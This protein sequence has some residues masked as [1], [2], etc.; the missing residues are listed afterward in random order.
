MGSAD[1]N[2]WKT[3][4]E[5]SKGNASK[6]DERKE[7]TPLTK[8]NVFEALKAL[9][10]QYRKLCKNSPAEIIIVGGGS[11]LLN[12]NF[13]DYTMDL[14]VI[15]QAASGMKDAILRVADQMALPSDWINTD[16]KFTSSYSDKL[17]QYSRHYASLNNGQI[18]IR[19]INA[20][21]LIAM[22]LQSGRLFGP[23]LS[24][25]VGILA[26]EKES[27]NEISAMMVTKAGKELYGD[28]FHVPDQIM[29]IILP[30]YDLSAGDLKQQYRE[31]VQQ[32]EEIK[33]EILE[34]TD[35]KDLNRKT[36]KEIALRLTKYREKLL[37]KN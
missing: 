37:G 16:F 15:M 29:N 9:A 34:R 6:E 28:N 13:R 27:G 22:K 23:D 25:A 7:E 31:L 24:G 8:N 33:Q 19:T 5:P 2:P 20:E 3:D 14:D 18:E 26:D 21:Y 12:Y 4:A 1:Q 10:K 30:C 32:S 36:A 17:A 35:E 11:I